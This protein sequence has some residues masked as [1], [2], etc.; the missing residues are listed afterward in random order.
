MLVVQR[1]VDA[2]LAGHRH[3]EAH[4]VRP[5]LLVG[6]Y[7]A[8]VVDWATQL[9]GKGIASNAAI[10][11]VGVACLNGEARLSV[12]VAA[13]EIAA[14]CNRAARVSETVCGSIDRNGCTSQSALAKRN[15]H[16]RAFGC[17]W[18]PLLR[19][20]LCVLK[21]EAGRDGRRRALR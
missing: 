15:A 13:R 7:A 3:R 14:V 10:L 5:V 2:I 4:L 18:W 12:D 20:S 11:A 9:D 19:V 1:G 8:D 16:S 6:D 21:R 17:G